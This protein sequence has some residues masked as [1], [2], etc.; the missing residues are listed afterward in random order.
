[1]SAAKSVK[2]VFRPTVELT[3]TPHR[4]RT[5]STNAEKILAYLTRLSDDTEPG[6]I[7]G[8]NCRS[9][10]SICDDAYYQDAIGRLHDQSG[11]WPGV[12]S[13]AY[14]DWRVQ[15]SDELSSANRQLTIP[16]WRAG[17]LT[18]ITVDPV[19]P[20]VPE[21]KHA[22][23]PDTS[24]KYP[25]TDLKALL[26]GGSK[27][28]RWLASLDRIA[29][30]LAELRDAGVVV[31]FRP[32]QEMNG[33]W[34]WWSSTSFGGSND[35]FIPLWRD[36]FNYFT[37]V[38]GLDNLLWVFAPADNP[39][40]APSPYPGADYVDIVAPTVYTNDLVFNDYDNVLKFGKPI[41]LS[42]YGPSAVA[43]DLGANGSFDDRKYIARL[44]SDYPRV[45]FF[46]SWNSWEGVKMSLADNLFANELMNDTRV[47]TR[48][49][50][51]W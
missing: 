12:L 15:S 38:K 43:S 46:V 11:K 35:D 6:V 4:A 39:W 34:Y 13:L 48:D 28:G 36:M 9:M 2:A 51:A 22:V 40:L 20:W 30:P 29:A 32:M 49:R 10:W 37:C 25:G 5:L 42:E 1:M 47:I 3:P 26:P 18:M 27:R 21:P 50:I 14:E 19:N 31:L 33:N 23:Y 41:A 24:R 7:I 8:Q 17:G 44:Q 45:A 16:H